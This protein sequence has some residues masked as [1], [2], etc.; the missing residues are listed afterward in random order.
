MAVASDTGT[1]QATLAQPQSVGT[2]DF[3]LLSDEDEPEAAQ[4][5]GTSTALPTTG[6][7][8]PA[9]QVSVV[10]AKAASTAG[11]SKKHAC[12]LC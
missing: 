3:V 7:N 8:M 11:I 6:L 1:D 10:I 2:D 4:A 9:S 12:L 5:A